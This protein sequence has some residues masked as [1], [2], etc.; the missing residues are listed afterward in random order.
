MEGKGGE[1]RGNVWGDGEVRG[2]QWQCRRLE[3]TWEG[4]WDGSARRNPGT[5]TS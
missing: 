2:R 3:R 4:G 5:Y 1:R